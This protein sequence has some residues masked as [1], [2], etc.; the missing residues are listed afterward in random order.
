M[1]HHLA[2]R[3]LRTGNQSTGV[4]PQ[5]PAASSTDFWGC[6]WHITSSNTGCARAPTPHHTMDGSRVVRDSLAP[7]P[8]QPGQ[9]SHGRRD[10]HAACAHQHRSQRCPSHRD[11]RALCRSLRGPGSP[12]SRARSAGLKQQHR[13]RRGVVRCAARRGGQPMCRPPFTEK[14]APVAKPASSLATHDTIEA[15][16]SGVPRRLTGMVATI[17]SSTS[18]RMARTISVPM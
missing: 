10:G 3:L 15:I 7:T 4:S 8:V 17:L 18:G 9:R 1:I 6:G 11:Q 16:S 13:A 14:S 2:L 12:R 5:T